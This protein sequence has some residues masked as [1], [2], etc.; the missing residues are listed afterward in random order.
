MPISKI[1]NAKIPQWIWRNLESNHILHK[2]Y[3]NVCNIVEQSSVY[4]KC[5][6]KKIISNLDMQN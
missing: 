2:L 5:E 4:C 1:T 3:A 6:N